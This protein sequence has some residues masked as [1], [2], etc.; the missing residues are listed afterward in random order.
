MQYRYLLV[1]LRYLKALRIGSIFT[2]V[3]QKHAHSTDHVVQLPQDFVYRHPTAQEMAN[4]L[5]S[6]T[7]GD[8]AVPLGV[9]MLE[10]TDLVR[11]MIEVQAADA[12]F[13]TPAQSSEVVLVTGTTGSLGSH[14]LHYL[15]QCK[16]IRRIYALN[17][18]NR[19]DLS[20]LRCRQEDAL[21][22]RGIAPE[23]L[24]DGKV[25]LVPSDLASDDLGLE[26]SLFQELRNSVDLIIHAAWPVNFNYTLASYTRSLQGLRNLINFARY[27][28]SNLCPRFIFTSSVSVL[29]NW[30]GD[31][32]IPE[33][34]L[35]DPAVAAGLGYAESK[36]AA[37]QILGEAA[38]RGL[39]VSI[40]RIGQLSGSPNGH[41]NRNEWFPCIVQAA[42]I[43]KCLPRIN[44]KFYWLP[45]DSAAAVI[46]EMRSNLHRYVHL[47]NSQPVSFYA[48]STGSGILLQIPIVDFKDWFNGLNAAQKDTTLDARGSL[49]RISTVLNSIVEDIAHG[50]IEMALTNGLQCSDTLRD[51]PRINRQDVSSWLRF[52]GAY[53]G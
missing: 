50:P 5:V 9:K 53:K 11:Q 44:T 3:L 13:K 52:W 35:P 4:A 32:P 7:T 17:R 8:L 41:W 46:V 31:S 40:F 47:A 19:D 37:E 10:M 22:I 18:G 42:N 34:A 33:I 12:P 49:N 16:D 45:V 21:R 2:S 51:T 29:K 30:S 6:R 36:W 27:T 23:I 14:I 38:D 48:G 1:R 24:R 39:C 28:T 26:L 43:L 20:G 25:V 15:H